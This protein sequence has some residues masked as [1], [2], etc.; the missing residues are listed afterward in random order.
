MRRIRQEKGFSLVEI[1]IGVAIASLGLFFISQLASQSMSSQNRNQFLSEISEARMALMRSDC[2]NT[3]DSLTSQGITCPA[4]FQN[5]Q[6]FRLLNKGNRHVP[7]R[8]DQ[9]NHG[10]FDI[11]TT[12]ASCY[13]QQS[14]KRVIFEFAIVDA[15]GKP[16]ADKKTGFSSAE[17]RALYGGTY[18][19]AIPFNRFP[20]P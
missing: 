16:R 3:Y 19:G 7:H 6:A 17:W 13:S 1:L 5:R 10:K 2:Q 18:K 9:F 20:C 14:I 11:I 12:R 4:G 15:T 8:Y